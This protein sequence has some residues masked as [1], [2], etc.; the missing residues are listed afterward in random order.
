MDAS[1]L[2]LAQKLARDLSET[3]GVLSLLFDFAERDFPGSE[4]NLFC[5]DC[6]LSLD[7]RCNSAT[8]HRY[9]CYEAERWGG[10]YVY[11]CPAS[12][13][14]LSTVI[15][16]RSLPALALVSG[17]VVMGAQEDILSDFNGEMLCKIAALPVRTP[18]AIGSLGRV[19]AA[20]VAAFSSAEEPASPPR[21][22]D[23]AAELKSVSRY[24]LETEQ[25]LIKMIISG[26]RAGA[27]ALINDLLGTLYLENGGNFA[28][29]KQGAGELLT[30]I[31]RAA[32]EGGA[33]AEHIFGEKRDLAGRLAAFRDFDSLSQFLVRVF[34]RFV[35]YSFDFRRFQHADV[36]HK[37]QEYVREHIG[38][39][40]LLSEL[41]KAVGLSK[42]YL[43][44]VFSEEMGKTLT[45]Y[46]QDA[47]IDYSKELLRGSTLS[48]AQV[49][50]L[51][52]FSDQS[53]FTKIFTKLCGVSPAQFRKPR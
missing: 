33:D 25:R 37:T 52:G 51:S 12:L 34:H 46:I 45:E 47:R 53:Y 6:E 21:N 4:K 28:A 9:G 39:R 15:Y 36:L 49:A 23:F 41:A 10:Q 43:S 32:I 16:E 31:S 24:P 27:G 5:A 38:E 35:S 2:K 7:G 48:I 14:F 13:T 50:S 3:S 42:S 17:P 30:L 19:Q 1:K 20:L 44:T 18:A 22:S 40:I 11:Y 26:D 8:A 29:L